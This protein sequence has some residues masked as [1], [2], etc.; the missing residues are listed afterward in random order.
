MSMFTPLPT[1]QEM[2][3]WDRYSI[4]DF[5]IEGKI[6]MENASREAL[7]VLLNSFG[8]VKDKHVLLLA[9]SGNNGGDA[10]ALGR[11]L[12]DH[13]ADCTI[14]HTRDKDQYKGETAYH[15]Q[16]AEKAGVS[17]GRLSDH[18]LDSLQEPDIIVDGL[19]GTGFQ[20]ELR[21]DY[22]NWISRI[23][24]FNTSFKLAIDIPSGLNGY[25]GTPSP[26]AVRADITVSFECP[27]LG[28]FMPEAS[29][30][31][32]ELYTPKIGIPAQIIK[33]QPSKCQGLTPEVF[34]C[35]P[36]LLET[37]HKSSAGHLLIIGGSPGLTGA[38][39][40]A[41]LGALKSGAG[42]CTVACPK[43]LAQDIKQGWP[44]IMT[45]PLGPGKY[46]AEASFA[47]LKD[48]LSSFDAV[49]LGPGIGRQEGTRE[50]M[51]NFLEC[52]ERPPALFD[53][54]A[55]Y[56]LAQNPESLNSLKKD[57]IL[58]PHPGE[59]SRLHKKDTSELQ[60]ARLDN[61]KDFADSHPGVLVLKGAGTVIAAAAEHTYISPFSCPNLAVG[62]SGDVL[63]GLIGSLKARKLGSIQAACLGVYW[64]GSAGKILEHHYPY[65]GNLAQDIAHYLPL[66][67][68]S[69]RN[70]NGDKKC[71]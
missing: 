44:E 48:S 7:H 17:F 23:N 70:S 38:P 42:L 65:R 11:H 36:G 3:E 67:A 46:L 62:G 54:D 27:K 28:L 12:F 57:D 21:E 20:G 40:L 50:F 34:S 59:M 5:G 68:A 10:F 16:L 39:T 63:A 31:I 71:N 53:A 32:G 61:A 55:L 45:L 4:Q 29:R 37:D 24:N 19:L 60:E 25:K 41:A 14:L 51:Q 66:A 2:G 43:Q 47:E 69:K 52:S 56:W 8:D 26:D 30:F 9:G 18:N 33:E 22:L 58:T 1:P 13:G 64:H 49:V 6:L 35:F 15:L